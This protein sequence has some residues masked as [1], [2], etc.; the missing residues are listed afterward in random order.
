MSFIQRL[1]KTLL[2]HRLSDAMQKESER[3]L[4]HCP[5]CAGTQSVWD[6]GGVRFGAASLA[7]KVRV[8][9]RHC[10]RTLMMRMERAGTE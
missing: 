1:V 5:A 4:L 2:P 3:W 9:C 10:G 6:V 8:R 7:K